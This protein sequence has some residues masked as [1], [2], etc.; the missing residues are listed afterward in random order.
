MLLGR[1][2][3]LPRGRLLLCALA[4]GI[5]CGCRDEFIGATPHERQQELASRSSRVGK[6]CL[7]CFGRHGAEQASSQS[8][9]D[10]LPVGCE[11]Q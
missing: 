7:L 8:A 6:K 9:D 4:L 3:R 10:A 5:E 2:R 11:P 1:R